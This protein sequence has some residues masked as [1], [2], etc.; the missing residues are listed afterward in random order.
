MQRIVK[1]ITRTKIHILA[2]LKIFLF[3]IYT[4]K[5]LPTLMSGM[6]IFTR[7]KCS[8]ICLL[9]GNTLSSSRSKTARHHKVLCHRI[10]VMRADNAAMLYTVSVTRID[11]I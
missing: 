1:L 4:K 5:S 3:S 7:E 10:A 6:S 2:Y 11:F 9:T 8:Y